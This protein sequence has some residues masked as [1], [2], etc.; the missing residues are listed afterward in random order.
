MS[1]FNKVIIMGNLTRDPEMRHTQGGSAICNMGV[2][3]SRKFRTQAGEDREDVC[4]VDV[5]VWGKQGE[6]CARYLKKGSSA[7][8]EGRLNFDQWDDQET[9]R[10]RSK[11]SVVGENVR[12]LSSG[13]RDNEEQAKSNEA[14][15]PR[16][17]ESDIPNAPASAFE[18]PEE[19]PISF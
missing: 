17:E 11:L 15:K 18:A 13:N 16:I 3:V 19:D 4:F 2:A 7:L 6:S 14:P 8:I 10:K 5:T 12:F 9:G 1:S